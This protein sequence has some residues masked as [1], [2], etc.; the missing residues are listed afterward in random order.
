M[1]DLLKR[2]QQLEPYEK[3]ARSRIVAPSNLSP[4]FLNYRRSRGVGV[5]E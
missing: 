1:P 2:L 4:S 5:G 3:N